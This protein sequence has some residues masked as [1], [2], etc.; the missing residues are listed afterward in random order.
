MTDHVVVLITVPSREV[1]EAIAGALLEMRLAACVNFVS[2]VNSWYVWHGELCRD[3]E[4]LLI[5]KTRADL[6]RNHLVPA[7]KAHHPYEVPEIIAIPI[8]MGAGDY[9]AWLDDNVAHPDAG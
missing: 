1:G 3:E 7:V 4:I 5:V 2:P 9:L 8:V 6:V